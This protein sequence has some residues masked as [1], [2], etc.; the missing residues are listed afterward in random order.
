MYKHYQIFIILLI[1]ARQF[2]LFLPVHTV[3][4]CH[5]HV[6]DFGASVH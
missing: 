6:A 5:V 3:S 1:L 2:Q 4:V